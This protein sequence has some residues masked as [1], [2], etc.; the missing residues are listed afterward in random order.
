MIYKAKSILVALFAL[1]LV[2]QPLLSVQ[3]ALPWEDAYKAIVKI[4]TYYEDDNYQLTPVQTGSGVFIQSEGLILTNR[5]VV[6]LEDIFGNELPVAYQICVTQST[7]QEPTCTFSADLVAQDADTD[8]ALLRVRHTMVSEQGSFD[9]LTRPTARSFQEGD[10]VEALGYPAVGG[11]TI[12]SAIGTVTGTV[13][14]NGIDWIKTNALVSY[15][16]SGGALIDLDGNVIGVTSAAN[17]SLGYAIA[18]TSIN[19]WI[20]VNK[21]APGVV[22]PLQARMNTL[23]V[24]Q[25]TVNDSDS[26]I[27]TLPYITVTK[28][29][30]WEFFRE[31]EGSIFLADT[32][33]GDSAGAVHISWF[34]ADTYAAPTLDANVAGIMLSLGCFGSEVVTVAEIEARKVS[35]LL[36][37]DEVVQYL[38]PVKQYFV[39]LTVYAGVAETSSSDIDSI[40]DSLIINGD[41]I[42]FVETHSYVHEMPYFSLD[43]SNEYTIKSK[44]NSF[45]PVTGQ[46]PATP[47]S[48]FGVNVDQLTPTM[49][50]MSNQEFFDFI[51]S[52]ELVKI[53]HEDMFGLEAERYFEDVN[54]A[55]TAELS[56]EIMM[57]YRF[58]DEDNNTEAKAYAASLYVREGEWVVLIKFSYIGSDQVYFESLFD[59]FVQKG[60]AGL[61]VGRSVEGIEQ[62]TNTQSQATTEATTVSTEAEAH[63]LESVIAVQNIGLSLIGRIVIRPEASGE[64]YYLYP[65]TNEAYF[66]GRPADAFKIMRELGLGVSEKDFASFNGY[67]PAHLAGKILIRPEANGEAYYV[68]PRDNKLH[69]LGRPQDAFDVMRELGLGV[70]EVDFAQL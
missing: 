20:E 48:S 53:E 67:A 70:S 60:L 55:A 16:S 68:D 34:A 19:S 69:F 43:M 27:N 49:Q 42:S 1:G 61:T 52:D 17:V 12:T 40:I 24:E 41:G 15:G 50:S 66:L 30:D 8:I 44:N 10:V 6:H 11:A 33:L 14:D 22:S 7:T 51:K 54:Y 2:M 32:A 4:I 62:M 18:V 38:V 37:G 46:R 31:D 59:H 13:H 35:C 29:T 63:D 47:E 21:N 3:A 23:I 57:K 36:A 5:H 39:L 9:T 58:V 64:A 28:P 65:D 56:N 45:N 25:A 26:F